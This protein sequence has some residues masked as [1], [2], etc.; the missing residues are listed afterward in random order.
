MMNCERGV[1]GEHMNHGTFARALDF[2]KDYGEHITIGGG[3]PTM[4]KDFFDFCQINH[5]YC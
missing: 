4:H 5:H 1:K 3:E 2:A